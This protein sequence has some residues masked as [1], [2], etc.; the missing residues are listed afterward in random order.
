[1]S[2]YNMDGGRGKQV[3]V[4]VW[5]YGNV[6]PSMALQSDSFDVYFDRERLRK[7]VASRFR[8]ARLSDKGTPAALWALKAD[9]QR[10]DAW[11]EG[12]DFGQV[13]GCR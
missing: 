5:H 13:F 12:R 4:V 6:E 2:N 10:P 11:S 7:L 1:M 3:A 8:A 9:G